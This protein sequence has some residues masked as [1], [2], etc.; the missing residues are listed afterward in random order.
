MDRDLAHAL[1]ILQRE[2]SR[3]P[4]SRSVAIAMDY[5]HARLP[6]N[7]PARLAF[8]RVRDNLADYR[9]GLYSSASG[10]DDYIRVGEAINALRDELTEDPQPEFTT[11]R[12]PG[13]L[14]EIAATLGVPS[15]WHEPDEQGVY[16][17]PVLWVTDGGFDNAGHAVLEKMIILYQEGVPRAQISL[18]TTLAWAAQA[19]DTA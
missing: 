1:D 16:A 4:D 12:T 18:A 14:R 17:A 7:T 6:V 11:I 19:P 10:N 5:L 9:N 2:A 8:L 13:Q 3:D 15:D